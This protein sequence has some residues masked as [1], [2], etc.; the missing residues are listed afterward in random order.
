[1]TTC[2]VSSWDVSHWPI[3]ALIGVHQ[4]YGVNMGWITATSAGV[5]GRGSVWWIGLLMVSW[6]DDCNPGLKQGAPSPTTLS[7][8]HVIYVSQLAALMAVCA[9]LDASGRGERA[10]QRWPFF[11]GGFCSKMGDSTKADQWIHVQMLPQ[12]YAEQDVWTH[13]YLPRVLLE[14]LEVNLWRSEET[15]KTDPLA[16]LWG[17]SR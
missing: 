4:P 8:H 10:T 14:G 7:L 11:P 17:L 6:L 13:S 5:R 1:M 12:A 9:L 2:R 16:W 15:Q 3:R